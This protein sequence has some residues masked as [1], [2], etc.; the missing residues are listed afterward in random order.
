VAYKIIADTMIGSNYASGKGIV[1]ETIDA[2]NSMRMDDSIR[3]LLPDKQNDHEAFDEEQSIMSK[4]TKLANEFNEPGNK[5][6]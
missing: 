3:G 4:K 1:D 6:G 2:G 5:K